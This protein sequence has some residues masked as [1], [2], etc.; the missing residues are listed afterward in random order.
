MKNS[1]ELRALIGI[2]VFLILTIGYAGANAQRIVGMEKAIGAVELGLPVDSSR[3]EVIYDMRVYDPVISD[4][5]EYIQIVQIG[6]SMRSER[7]YG[8]FRIDSVLWLIHEPQIQYGEYMKIST[9]YGKTKGHRGGPR[10][11]FDGHRWREVGVGQP[12]TMGRTCAYDSTAIQNWEIVDETKTLLGIECRKAQCRFRGRNWT[13]WYA[14]EI[15]VPAG[16]WKLGGLPGLIVQAES[17]DKEYAIDAMQIRE[18]SGPIL[19][20]PQKCT[21]MTRRMMA[22]KIKERSEYPQRHWAEDGFSSTGMV[23]LNERHFYNPIEKS[24]D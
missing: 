16:P 5:R 22:E 14:P 4:S 9:G 6:D 12:L 7:P 11:D 10:Y 24:L 15:P 8:T 19:L 17:A 3:I 20:K 2:V 13:V 18:G 1:N 21:V 23:D